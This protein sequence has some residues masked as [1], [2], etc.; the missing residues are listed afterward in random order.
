MSD[1]TPPIGI[2]D[3]AIDLSARTLLGSALMLPYRWRVPLFGWAASAIVAPIAGWRK[4]VRDNLALALP[5]LPVSEVRRLERVVANNVGRTLIEIYSG[6]DFVAR[7]RTSPIDGPGL[8]SMRAARAAGRPMVLA[9]AHMGNYDA[10]RGKLSREGYDIGALYRPMDNRAF[11][12]HYV[13]AISAIAT[14][15]FPTDGNGIRGL[16]RHLSQGGVMGIVVDVASTRAPVLEFFG[17][18]AHT[19]LSAAEWA[20]K[21]DAPMIPIF[22]LRQPDGLSFR[23]HVGAPIEPG[24]PEEMMQRYNDAL[25]VLVR[26]DPGQWFWIHR[27]WKRGRV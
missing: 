14:P 8:E 16:V 19:P 4:R 21:Y 27:R 10:V 1:D 17:H 18:P 22:G 15:V 20:L 26:A 24:T 7:A 25:E 6:D 12:G 3:R 9:T 11:N 5:D 13:R 2:R 23:I